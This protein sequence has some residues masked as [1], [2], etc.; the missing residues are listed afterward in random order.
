MIMRSGVY[1]QFCFV[2]LSS[3]VAVCLTSLTPV[4]QTLELLSLLHFTMPTELDVGNRSS[5][6]SDKGTGTVRLGSMRVPICFV[7]LMIPASLGNVEILLF[8]RS[9]GSRIERT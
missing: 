4:I 2:L 8:P 7:G 9:V 6:P 5:H 1:A 3:R